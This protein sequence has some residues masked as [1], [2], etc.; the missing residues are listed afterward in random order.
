M[1]GAPAV[2]M[3]PK[4][5][6]AIRWFTSIPA[7]VRVSARGYRNLARTPIMLSGKHVEGVAMKETIKEFAV[8]MEVKSKG[9]NSKCDHPMAPNTWVT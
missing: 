6:A 5:S 4:T 9:L 2:V 1:T 7:H 8:D 3:A